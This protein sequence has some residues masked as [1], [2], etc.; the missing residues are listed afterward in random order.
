MKNKERR[1]IL[2][3]GTEAFQ[4]P[5]WEIQEVQAITLLVIASCLIAKKQWL[6]KEIK[7]T[8]KMNTEYIQSS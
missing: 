3:H 4:C 6:K 7:E 5:V 2:F 1:Q 8:E